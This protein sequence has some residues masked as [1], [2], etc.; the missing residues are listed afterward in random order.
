M[1]VSSLNYRYTNPT[2]S[3]ENEHVLNFA[4]PYRYGFGGHE[5]EGELNE[6]LYSFGDYG[7]DSRIGRRWNPDPEYRDL[8]GQTPYA[9][10]LNSPLQFNDPTG[11]KAKVTIQRNETGGGTIT[12]STVVYVSGL[13]K[14]NEDVFISKLNEES[15]ALLT[16]GTY[17]D[18]AGNTWDVVFDVSYKSGKIGD[19]REDQFFNNQ[20]TV[21][22][23]KNQS[24]PTSGIGFITG[25][26][27]RGV[28]KGKRE[29]IGTALEESIHFMGLGDQYNSVLFGVQRQ[30]IGFIPKE[31]F[32]GDIL[33]GPV[34]PLNF[35]FTQ[36][37]IDIIGS[38]LEGE[39]ALLKDRPSPETLL[40]N[41]RI[42]GGKGT[43]IFENL[44]NE[45]QK[46]V[47]RKF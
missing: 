20:L 5:G 17:L 10:S 15:K 11:E 43:D 25:T 35:E 42:G 24:R 45:R 2:L 44:S 14:D 38:F 47:T 34:R 9:F 29:K 36:G 30:E 26:T 23:T 37:N 13:T 31:G 1:V 4:N 33:T 18:N 19:S 7:Y 27:V 41:T 8:P 12:I 32:E 46:Q 40:I 39:G 28:V 6:E 21:D 16:N 3:T 22:D